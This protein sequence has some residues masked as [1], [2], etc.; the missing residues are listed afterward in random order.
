MYGQLTETP[1]RCKG[2]V[3]LVLASGYVD[4]SALHECRYPEI[5]MLS[6]PPFRREQAGRLVVDRA[7]EEVRFSPDNLSCGVSCSDV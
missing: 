7:G 6:G 4:S 5:D 1:L 3:S 2:V